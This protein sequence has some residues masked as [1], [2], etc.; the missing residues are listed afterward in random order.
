MIHCFLFSVDGGTS[1]MEFPH[2]ESMHG[3]TVMR[4]SGMGKVYL[5][6]ATSPGPLL[7]GTHLVGQ[8]EGVLSMLLSWADSLGVCLWFSEVRV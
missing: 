3:R 1:G 5:L 4:L 2:L 8:G 7:S 6:W